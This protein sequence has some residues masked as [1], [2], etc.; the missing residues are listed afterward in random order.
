VIIA[1]WDMLL[2]LAVSLVL[3]KVPFAGSFWLLCL[4]SFLFILTT[5]GA[6]LLISTVSKTQ[7]QANM[8]TFLLFQPFMMLSGFTF[9]ITSMPQAVQWFTLINPMRYFLEIVRGIFLRGSGMDTLW[10]NLVA[11]AVFGVSILWF[12]VTRF[13]KTLE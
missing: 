10:P 12:S 13:H 4:A 7:Q 1:F 5:L 11:L 9:P 3:F 6:G 8:A 2:V